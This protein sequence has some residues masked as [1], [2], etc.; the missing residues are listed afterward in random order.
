MKRI[1]SNYVYNLI[2]QF[3][4]FLIPIFLIPFVIDKLG[5]ENLGIEAYTLTLIGFFVI[6]A[7]FGIGTFGTREVAKIRDNEIKL[8]KEVYK[9]IIIKLLFTFLS[10]LCFLIFSIN[11]D[12]VFFLMLQLVYFFG[13]TIFDMNWY[14]AGLEK[15]KLI[16]L[17][18]LFIKVTGAILIFTLVKDEDDFGIYI[19]IT[20]LVILIPNL[21]FFVKALKELGK[22]EFTEFKKREFFQTIRTIFPFFLLGLSIQ[23]YM[24]IDKIIIE[25]FSYTYELGIYNQII[26]VL[27]AVIGPLTAVGTILMPYFSNIKESSGETNLLLKLSKSLNFLMILSIGMFCGIISISSNVISLV[28]GDEFLIYENTF[29]IACLM[30][31]TTALYN[32]VIQQILYPLNKERIYL[33]AVGF[34]SLLKMLLLFYVVPRFNLTAIML[35]YIICEFLILFLCMFF[36]RKD[37]SFRKVFLR[38]NLMKIFIAGLVMFIFLSIVSFPVFFQIIYGGIIYIFCLLILGET[39]VRNIV[40]VAFKKK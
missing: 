7:N 2:Y 27:F 39:T 9:I 40:K 21:Y 6:F 19:L 31:L 1:M 14:Y 3:S 30:I 32:F 37:I 11:N 24:N 38:F 13:S 12:Y 17:R 18:N 35:V 25:H 33:F 10:F 20:G 16:V 23:F 29:K 15:F 28:L 5:P 8:K 4:T 34:V 22:P 36:I 26:K